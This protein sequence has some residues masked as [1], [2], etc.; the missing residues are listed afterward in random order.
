MLPSEIRSTIS[1]DNAV[2]VDVR[3][4][5]WGKVIS[6]VPVSTS[7]PVAQSLLPYAV[8][9][10]HGWRFRP[11]RQNGAAVRSDKVLEFLFRPSDL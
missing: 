5:E 11:A 7:G 10:A 2:D 9:A 8:Q 3:I 6:A 4:D 1:S